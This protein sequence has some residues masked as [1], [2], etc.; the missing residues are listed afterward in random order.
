MTGQANNREPERLDLKALRQRL[1]GQP[2][3]GFSIQRY[4]DQLRDILAICYQSE[5]ERRGATFRMDAA[6]AEHIDKA[7]GWL[8][9]VSLPKQGLIICGNTGNGKTTMARAIAKVIELCNGGS[10]KRITALQYAALEA[11]RDENRYRIIEL[12]Q[13]PVLFIDDLGTEESSVRV[14]GNVISP[15]VEL[16]YQRYDFQA[17]TIAT[18]NLTTKAL[19]EKYGERIGDRMREMFN[20]ISFSNPSYRAGI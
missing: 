13:A 20:V 12:R 14:Y 3:N 19:T 6:T 18:S 16:L 17:F 5:V 2:K 15:V 11:D 10:V 4:R 9:R 1:T 8:E 7:A